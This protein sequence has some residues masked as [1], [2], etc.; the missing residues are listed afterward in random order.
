VIAGSEEDAQGNEDRL[1]G[2]AEDEDVLRPYAFVEPR[3]LA[4]QQGMSRDLRVSEPQV[5]PEAG[6]LSSARA[7]AMQ[8]Q[9]FRVGGTRR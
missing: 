6:G 1:L 2:P 7:R 3:D 4:P 8:G 5:R 9:R